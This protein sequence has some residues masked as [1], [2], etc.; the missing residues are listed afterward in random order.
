[1]LSLPSDLDTLSF[2]LFMRCDEFNN[3]EALRA[4]FSTHDLFP[5][6]DNLPVFSDKKTFVLEVKLLLLS[7]VL[8]DGR[9]LM[10]P[11]LAT[12]RDQ[13][14]VGRGERRSFEEVIRTWTVEVLSGVEGG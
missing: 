9:E 14:R 4:V 10:L 2:S 1:M 8:A 6:R 12:L 13:C 3:V 11:F 7:K 5:F